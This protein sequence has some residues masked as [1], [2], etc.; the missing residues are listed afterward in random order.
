MD[1][2]L[3]GILHRDIK[4]N[5]IFCTQHGI[6]KLGDFGVRQVLL[7]DGNARDRKGSDSSGPPLPITTQQLVRSFWLPD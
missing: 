6:L 7:K 2:G 4:T 1:D 3:Q 5:N